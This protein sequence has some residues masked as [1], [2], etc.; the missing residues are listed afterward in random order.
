MPNLNE[1]LK[2][3]HDWTNPDFFHVKQGYGQLL[4]PLFLRQLLPIRFQKTKLSRIGWILIIVAI[5]IGY[6]AYN[7]SSNILFMTLS[8]LLSSLILSGILSLIN[9]RGL[10]WS[11][12]TPKR[13]QVGEVGIAEIYL[14][15]DKAV[16]PTMSICF[17]VG[18]TACLDEEQIYLQRPLKPKRSMRL[19]WTFIP[20][21]RGR[22]EV[23]LSGVSSVF[24][25]GFLE[26]V[27]GHAVNE[28]VLVWPQAINYTFT[29]VS[30]GQRFLLGHPKRK[31]GQGSDLLNIRSY[32]PGDSPRLIHWKATARSKKMMVRQ[33]AQEGEAG[34]HLVVDR[35]PAVWSQ[36]NFETLCSL[37]YSLS[38]ALFHL[39]RLDS[40]SIDELPHRSVKNLRELHDFFDILALLERKPHK[41][42][43]PFKAPFNSITFRPAAKNGVA[44]YIDEEK[45]GHTDD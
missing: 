5:G 11:L 19:E 24:P 30:E 14:E 9:F 41:R 2:G 37:L 29:V 34:Y 26:R 17:S 20:Q 10:K 21:R 39:G 25:F 16:F 28:T 36:E 18:T 3:W 45:S 8:L 1:E 44:I 27:M 43:E 12:R 23:F 42:S 15:N 31:A 40:I 6:A 22:C 32:A 4:I 38:E 35:D 13:L 7:T 33:L